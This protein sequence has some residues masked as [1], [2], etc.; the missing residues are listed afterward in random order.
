MSEAANESLSLSDYLSIVR[1]RGVLIAVSFCSILLA[2]ASVALLVPPIYQSTGTILIES[3]Q[4]P[5]EL[6]QATVT[7]YAEERI[8]ITKQRVMTRENLL[9]IVGKYELFQDS[10]RGITPSEQIDQMRKDTEI[11]LIHANLRAGHQG[12]S[13][14]A[15]KLSFDHRR[16]DVAQKVANELVTLFLGENAKVRTERATQT[17]E[18]LKQESAR[19]RLE[20]DKLET[21]IATYKQEHSRAL[22]ENTAMAMTALQR[23][24]TDLRQ[25]ERDIR[26]AEDELRYLEVE[27]STASTQPAQLPPGAS[28][29]ALGGTAADLPRMRGELTRLLA[30]YTENHPDVR[31]MQRRIEK[32]EAAVA[33]DKQRPASAG[34][35]DAP[36]D[37]TVARL[38][39]RIATVRSRIALLTN[40]Q[41]SLRASIAQVDRS[42][43]GA[44]QVER[45]LAALTR[46]YQ[47]AQRKYEEIRS[48]QSTAQ[49]A[50]NL[51]GEQKAERFTLL[52]PPTVP[53]KPIKPD[54][55]KLMAM[56]FLLALVG[57]AG[58]V[59][60]METVQGVVRGYEPIAGLMGQRPL[61]AV[62]F[63]PLAVEAHQRRRTQ[64][65]FAGA[66]CGLLVAI[67][68]GLHF[69]Y[70]PLD[71][72]VAKVMLRLS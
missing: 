55:K 41:A 12:S 37:A 69:A 72:L 53:D 5:T 68:T 43:A 54:R 14:I 38:D 24:E 39:G 27:R 51:E 17:T 7:S 26:A 32:L 21:Q 56:G 4:I 65:M 8:A 48:K 64:L 44:P 31:A 22:P 13:T 6:V 16:P 52:E 23:L 47:M 15:F 34:T 18:F 66:S 67:L 59:L 25:T 46:D 57:T 50:E 71:M 61:V 63:I 29:A 11:E 70:M 45:G 58:L 3:Q 40:Q 10:L 33:A 30:M 19:M 42:L 49:V 35:A 1:R 60:L 28:P 20:L 62:P 9:R 2:S 36:R